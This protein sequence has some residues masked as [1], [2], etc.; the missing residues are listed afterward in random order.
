[1]EVQKR[2]T[3]QDSNRYSNIEQLVSDI[4]TLEQYCSWKR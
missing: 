3:K 2:E 4:K 1:M